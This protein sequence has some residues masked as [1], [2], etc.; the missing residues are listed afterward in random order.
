MTRQIDG[1]RT[2]RGQDEIV[3]REREDIHDFEF[4]Y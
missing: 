4:N 2:E 1:S 3:N